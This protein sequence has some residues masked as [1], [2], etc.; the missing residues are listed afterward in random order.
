MKEHWFV[1]KE[2]NSMT[3]EHSLMTKECSLTTKLVLL[4][5][6]EV[7]S[8]VKIVQFGRN[9]WGRCAQGASSQI[10]AA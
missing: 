9:R 3:K 8:M 2:L 1:S 6:K 4:V 7:N 10:V 5:T